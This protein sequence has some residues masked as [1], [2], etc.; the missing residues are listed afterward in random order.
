MKRFVSLLLLI[1][2]IPT[3]FF[4]CSDDV[5][6]IEN[7]QEYMTDYF[8]KMVVEFNEFKYEEYY[9]HFEL[10]ESEKKQ[11]VNSL[12]LTKDTF[13]RYYTLE[14]IKTEYIEATNNVVCE[15]RYIFATKLKSVENYSASYETITYTLTQVDGEYKIINSTT[16]IDE[17]IQGANEYF[18]K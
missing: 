10:E 5:N 15:V 17:H 4:S 13:D 7:L 2:C 3:V 8:E 11:R 9:D 12:E 6:D 14:S 16:P 18:N 1:L